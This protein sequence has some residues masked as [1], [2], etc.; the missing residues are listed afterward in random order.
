MTGGEI[1]A[2]MEEEQLLGQPG[3][4]VQEETRG[5]GRNSDGRRNRTRDRSRDIRRETKGM[6]FRR[7]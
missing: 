5:K 4:T 3:R 1:E 2:N 6:M 7:T